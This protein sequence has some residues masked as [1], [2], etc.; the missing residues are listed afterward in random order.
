MILADGWDKI[1]ESERET[2]DTFFPDSLSIKW[3]S[4]NEQKFYNGVFTLPYEKIVEKALDMGI[5]NDY[6]SNKILHFIAEVQ[7]K[8]KV[9]VWIQKFNK[10]NTDLKFKIGTYQAKE[11][12]G[13]WHI[14]DDRS[15]TDTISNINIAQKVALVLEQHRYKLDIKLPN[16]YS[17]RDSSFDLFNQKICFFNQ[18]K[19]KD[20]IFNFLPQ[21]FDLT[22]GKG[23]KNFRAGFCFYENEVL[24]AFRKE[25]TTKES[26]Q[27]EELILE[28]IVNDNN[29]EIKVILRNTK[30]NAEIIFKDKCKSQFDRS[31]IQIR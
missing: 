24:K 15:E 6:T 11:I 7:P 30:T 1:N 19:W 8:G 3:F 22:W 29:D 13:T 26:S 21:G 14:F 20:T 28:L 2:A 18:S 12:K 17:L 5:K 9:A 31:I 16:G 10:D 27:A 23:N 25:Y 4:Y